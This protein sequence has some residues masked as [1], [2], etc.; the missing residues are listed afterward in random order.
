MGAPVTAFCRIDD[1]PIR[2]REP[3][4][5][6][7]ALIVQD[8]TLLHCVPLFDGLLPERCW[9]L[10]AT[11]LGL[12]H[13]GRP[14][15]NA[16]LLGGFAGIS[17]VLNSDSVGQAFISKF[18]GAAGEKN[19]AAVGYG[20]PRYRLPRTVSNSEPESVFKSITTIAR[21]VGFAWRNAH[22]APSR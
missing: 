7:D 14:I 2:L 10:P 21:D 3:V 17:G 19:V 18:P 11:R 1:K 5:E 9:T 4:V 20:I 15:P 16:A 8:A 12:E 13:V 6:P 22:V